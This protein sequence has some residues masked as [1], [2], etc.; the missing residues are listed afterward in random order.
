MGTDLHGLREDVKKVT[1][2]QKN[3]VR[4]LAALGSSLRD[5]VSEE[6]RDFRSDLRRLTDRVGRLERPAGGE[7]RPTLGQ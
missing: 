3:A 7:A 4:E 2:A 5:T 6:L 1:D